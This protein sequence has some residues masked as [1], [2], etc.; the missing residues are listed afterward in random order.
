MMKINQ[1]PDEKMWHIVMRRK[2]DSQATSREAPT[3]SFYKNEKQL[4]LRY[5]YIIIYQE[6]NRCEK[7]LILMQYIME[8]LAT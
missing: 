2:G 4:C 1:I 3:W 6:L 5:F 7:K 8:L